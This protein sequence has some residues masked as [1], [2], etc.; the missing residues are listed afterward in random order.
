MEE[1]EVLQG[2]D[3]LIM[4]LLSITYILTGVGT[5]L[6]MDGLVMEKPDGHMIIIM[7]ALKG[8]VQCK[9]IGILNY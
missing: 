8:Q 5:V 3:Q 7:T 6:I 4:R 2:Q 1:E 9:P